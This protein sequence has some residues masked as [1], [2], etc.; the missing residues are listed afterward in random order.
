MRNGQLYEGSF[1]SGDASNR[2]PAESG[3]SGPAW[4]PD[5]RISYSAGGIPKVF[6]GGIFTE[7]AGSFPDVH[8]DG[9]KLI[10]EAGGPIGVMNIDGSVID[11][12]GA[13]TDFF[14]STPVW[15]GPLSAAF[16]GDSMVLF[17]DGAGSLLVPDPGARFPT[18]SPGGEL[19]WV[20]G[21]GN[22]MVGPGSG[23]AILP[24]GPR[25]LRGPLGAQTVIGSW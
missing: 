13:D 25:R 24:P 6:G 8:P 17:A 4:A 12:D 21:D 15:A 22:V 10:Y 18:F 2:T 9:T 16:S 3:V 7:S 5:G 23:T 20:R 1:P 14:G 11:L 19:A